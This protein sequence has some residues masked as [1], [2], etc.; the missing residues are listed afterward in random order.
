MGPQTFEGQANVIRILPAVCEVGSYSEYDKVKAAFV[1]S[2][3]KEVVI[4][5]NKIA[6]KNY[7]V[8]TVY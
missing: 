1:E 5:K 7:L 4:H 8:K 6:R 3:V 2:K